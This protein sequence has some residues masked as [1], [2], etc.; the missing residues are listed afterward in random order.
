M[1]GIREVVT[2]TA[3]ACSYLKTVD[4]LH[5]YKCLF[6]MFTVSTVSMYVH[7]R[8]VR[9]EGNVYCKHVLALYV[10]LLHNKYFQK[11]DRYHRLRVHTIRSMLC[12]SMSNHIKNIH[13][14]MFCIHSVYII[15]YYCNTPWGVPNQYST[16]PTL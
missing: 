8:T 1:D 16:T 7:I 4:I 6:A 14:V 10:G 15:V 3:V 11:R 9:P 13:C 12:T 5:N 2:Y